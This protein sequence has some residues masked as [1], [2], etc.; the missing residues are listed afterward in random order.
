MSADDPLPL[1]GPEWSRPVPGCARRP[2]P[3][4]LGRQPGWSRRDFEPE[5]GHCA[6]TKCPSTAPEQV[7]RDRVEG[8]PISVPELEGPAG[9]PTDSRETAPRPPASRPAPPPQSPRKLPPEPPPGEPPR[10]PLPGTPPGRPPPNRSI[11]GCDPGRGAKRK[12]W[13]HDLGVNHAPLLLPA[14]DRASS[15]LRTR[16]A[17]TQARQGHDRRVLIASTRCDISDRSDIQCITPSGGSV[18]SVAGST[19][20]HRSRGRPFVM[21][22]SRRAMPSAAS[23]PSARPISA[24]D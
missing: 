3:A 23:T 1:R 16:H 12:P 19:G 14:V 22:T 8:D 11:G 6:R 24:A 20:I 18:A 2:Q 7:R 5:S 21:S 4:P 10:S 17:S 9:I 15:G 13:L